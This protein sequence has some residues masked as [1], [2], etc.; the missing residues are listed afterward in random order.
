[1]VTD[2]VINAVPTRADPAAIF[3]G[4]GHEPIYLAANSRYRLPAWGGALLTLSNS[5]LTMQ[6]PYIRC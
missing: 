6:Q 4:E 5:I 1:M 3:W 2:R